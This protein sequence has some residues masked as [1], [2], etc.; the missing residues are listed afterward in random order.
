MNQ[1]KD[2]ILSRLNIVDIISE[3]VVLKKAGS[4]YVG[5][6]PFHQEKTPSFGVNHTKQ[7][8]R[9]FGCG[10]AG[11]IFNFYMRYNN[12]SFRDT[13]KELAIRAGVE[14]KDFKSESKEEIEKKESIKKSILEINKSAVEFYRWN[15]LNSENGQIARDYIKGRR[16]SKVIVEKFLL[17]YSPNSWD[18]LYQYLRKNFSDEEIKSSGLVKE[19]ENGGFYDIFRNRLIFPIQNDTDQV[20]AFGGR[21]LEDG[22]PKYINSPETNIYIKG[23]NLYGLNFS[24]NKIREVG[25]IILV[26]GYIDVITCHEYGFENTVASLGTALTTEQAKKILRY[27][28]SKKVIVAYDADK[29]GQMAA[30][31]G[32]NILEQVSKGTGIEIFI[33]KVPEGKD[34]DDFLRNNDKEAFQKLLDEVLPVLEFELEKALSVNLNNIQ[35][36]TKALD[37]C[38]QLLLKL[39]ND[40]YINELIKKIVSWKHEGK[41]IDIREED[42]RSRL[43]KF[44]PKENTPTKKYD[45]SKNMGSKF[46]D[47]KK[48][49]TQQMLAQQDLLKFEKIKSQIISEKGLIYFLIERFRAIEYIKSRIKDVSF[50]DDINENIKEKIIELSTPLDPLSWEVL[51]Q[52]MPQPDFQRRIVEI[53]EDFDII[54][55]SS[56]KVLKDYIKQVQFNSLKLQGDEIKKDMEILL[57]KGEV[58]AF[59]KLMEI[60]SDIRKKLE[61][62]K[63]DIYSN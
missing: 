42:I 18:A 28:P 30:E 14:L 32:T 35:E 17:G 61:V 39:E 16:L 56:D 25:T 21:I 45:Y 19:K 53:W 22:Q 1:V 54:D 51:L 38:I 37:T 41:L 4:N 24:R 20:I 60:F 55:I 13:I 58:D 3:H 47:P 50:E 15:Y 29:A 27:T 62:M 48:Y 2:E 36:K 7:I 49:Y 11:N 23:Q 31:K 5:L 6:C 63:R 34:P 57:S 33:L 46:F 9:C 59:R 10:E 8:F 43:K 12:I 40:I 44:T 52:R 26:E